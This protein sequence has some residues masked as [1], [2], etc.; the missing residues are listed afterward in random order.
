MFV[1]A[2]LVYLALMASATAPAQE[3]VQ[4]QVATDSESDKMICKRFRE[5]G[6]RLTNKKVCKTEKEWEEQ[7]AENAA[8][9]RQ[10]RGAAGGPQPGNGG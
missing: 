6:S 4:Q 2:S 1:Q 7:R 8:A 9:M 3:V 5:T 10:K